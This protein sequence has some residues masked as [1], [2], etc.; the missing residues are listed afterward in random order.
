MTLW[1][2]LR[3]INHA[4]FKVTELEQ[5]TSVEDLSSRMGRRRHPRALALTVSSRWR[6]SVLPQAAGGGGEKLKKMQHAVV[7]RTVSTALVLSLIPMLIIVPVI[8]LADQVRSSSLCST[9]DPGH[10]YS[11]LPILCEA[12]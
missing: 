8:L 5:L 4:W 12:V 1:N 7:E 9:S 6:T 11:S 10:R 2:L 3:S